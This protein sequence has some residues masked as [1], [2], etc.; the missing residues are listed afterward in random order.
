MAD[1][2]VSAQIVVSSLGWNYK[3]STTVA[4]NNFTGG[5]IFIYGSLQNEHSLSHTF[6]VRLN[7]ACFSRVCW[8]KC[9]NYESV[10]TSSFIWHEFVGGIGL[11]KKIFLQ[12]VFIYYS[13]ACHDKTYPQTLSLFGYLL[14]TVMLTKCLSWLE[15]R[16]WCAVRDMTVL[17]SQLKVWNQYVILS[18]LGRGYFH[19]S[20]KALYNLFV[21]DSLNCFEGRSIFADIY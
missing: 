17:T 19:L 15:L 7:D 10:L 13:R 5:Q 6:A 11:I 21:C 1:H 2:S 4:S 8:W 12:A 20:N 3:F 16:I 18:W 9:P 14:Y